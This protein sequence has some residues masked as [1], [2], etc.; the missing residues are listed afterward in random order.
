MNA[1]LDEAMQG[2]LEP[3][4]A[5]PGAARRHACSA[6]PGMGMLTSVLPTTS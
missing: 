2:E 1:A 3:L 4:G 5:K 6:G